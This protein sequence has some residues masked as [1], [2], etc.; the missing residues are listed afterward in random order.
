MI[1]FMET[2]EHNIHDTADATCD[3]EWG[4]RREKSIFRHV[5]T[6]SKE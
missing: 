3:E 1:V 6:Q 5:E 4:K 2:F